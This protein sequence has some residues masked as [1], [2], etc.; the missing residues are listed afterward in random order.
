MRRAEGN[1]RGL[2]RKII[3][4]DEEKID[5][6]TSAAK[7]IGLNF[8]PPE[9]GCALCPGGLFVDAGRLSGYWWNPLSDDK[10]KYRLAMKCRLFGENAGLL[11]KHLVKCQADGLP[12]GGGRFS[13]NSARRFLKRSREAVER[14]CAMLKV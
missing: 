9:P 12:E 10:E 7:A 13:L 1:H 6:L 11:K 3:M 14:A 8:K 5:L 2:E 4:T